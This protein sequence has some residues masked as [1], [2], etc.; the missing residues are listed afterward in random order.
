MLKKVLTGTLVLFVICT[1]GTTVY[2]INGDDTDIVKENVEDVQVEK[3]TEI[4]SPKDNYITSEK[5]ILLS[6]KAEENTK[7]VVEVYSKKKLTETDFDLKLM[8]KLD[9]INEEE[10]EDEYDLLSKD[11]F[12]VGELGIFAQQLE[13][14][15]G[16]NKIVIYVQEDEETSYTIIK[17][18]TVTSIEKAKKAL[19]EI[20]GA[21]FSDALLEQIK[22]SVDK[23]DTSK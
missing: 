14:A 6:G 20:K 16:L 13:L 22:N 8:P 19:E 2:A 15:D 17:Y 3:K 11:S 1:V 9:S 10:L 5:V 4:I 23:T 18:V 12:E 21:N 7:I